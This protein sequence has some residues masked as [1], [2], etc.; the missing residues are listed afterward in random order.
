M[1]LGRMA[2]TALVLSSLVLA[3][4]QTARKR[5]ASPAGNRDQENV[6][7]VAKLEDEMRLAALK[8]T[9]AWWVEHLSEA[10]TGTDAQGKVSNKEQTVEFQRSTDLVFDTWNLSDRAVHTFNG[11]TVIVTGKM[12]LD[13]TYR[14]QSLSGD[15]Q[16]TRVWVKNSLV[17]E[18]AASQL[19]KVGPQ[20]SAPLAPGAL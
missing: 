12:T 8:G 20:S 11:D 14:G 1:R 6:Q 16:F 19:T 15:F 5:T 17:W 13:G 7:A 10:Y 2:I 3:Y 4:S 18:L 9:A